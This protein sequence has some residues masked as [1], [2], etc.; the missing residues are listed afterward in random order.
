MDR[1]YVIEYV[2]RYVI[3]EFR[4]FDSSVF[5]DKPVSGIYPL[6]GITGETK[7]NTP[8]MDYL[9]EERWPGECYRIFLPYF[10]IASLLTLRRGYSYC[11]QEAE[12]AIIE[13]LKG[14]AIEWLIAGMIAHEVRHRIQYLLQPRFFSVDSLTDTTVKNMAIHLFKRR[15]QY[16]RFGPKDQ[17]KE[18]DATVVEVMVIHEMLRRGALDDKELFHVLRAEPLP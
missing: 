17:E 14:P 2:V 10:N 18:F 5:P 12:S 11:W 1:G 9:S 15:P 4:R 8:V 16:K 6:R 13:K 3:E 7:E